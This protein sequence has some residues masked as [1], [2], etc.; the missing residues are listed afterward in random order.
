MIK[1][2]FDG[3]FNIL[4]SIASIVL[5]PLNSLVIDNFPDIAILI[6]RFNEFLNTYL[7]SNLGFF[8]SL[9]PPKTRTLILFYLT[10][11]TIRFVVVLNAHLILKIFKIIKNIKV[12]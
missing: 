5:T 12:W 11:L 1:I 8:G 4:S 6:N 3:L 10:Y 2:F 7:V 9:V